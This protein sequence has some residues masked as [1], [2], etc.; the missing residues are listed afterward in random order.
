MPLVKFHQ[1]TIPLYIH[2]LKDQ[3]RIG[4][5]STKNMQ[6]TFEGQGILSFFGENETLLV[7]DAPKYGMIRDWSGRDET[8]SDN[9]HQQ[10]PLDLNA[11]KFIR[12][13]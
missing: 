6:F 2:V 7:L 10:L 13:N 11:L 12:G 9:S 4:F 5:K 3:I 8:L 1:E